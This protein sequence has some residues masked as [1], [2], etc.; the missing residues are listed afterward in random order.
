[1]KRTVR[2]YH[3]KERTKIHTPRQLQKEKEKEKEK[4][5]K[6]EK[7]KRKKGHKSTKSNQNQKNQ[8]TVRQARPGPSQDRTAFF[9]TR[10]H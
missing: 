3:K 7:E 4:E 1:M 2:R 5:G 9:K 10:L 8:V 6:K